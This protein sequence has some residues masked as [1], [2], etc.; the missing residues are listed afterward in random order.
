MRDL[1]L[2]YVLRGLNQARWLL[3]SGVFGE[4]EHVLH[5]IETRGLPDDPA[6][7][8]Q[9]SDRECLPARGLVAQLEAFARCG[10]DHRVVTD[11]IAGADRVHADLRRWTFADQTFATM[12]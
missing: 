9:C 4:P 8:A 11:H 6:C 3:A 12:R 10:E 5:V 2:P 7:R 1:V